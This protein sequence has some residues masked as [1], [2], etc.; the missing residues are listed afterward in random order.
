VNTGTLCRVTGQ[1]TLTYYAN[2]TCT[3]PYYKQP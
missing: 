3:I 2:G 1:T